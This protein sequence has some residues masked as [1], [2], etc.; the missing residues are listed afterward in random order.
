M[1]VPTGTQKETHRRSS[2][3]SSR[4]GSKRGSYLIR[5]CNK[6][7]TV[8]RGSSTTYPIVL[9]ILNCWRATEERAGL[10]RKRSKDRQQR[11]RRQW[12]RL[13][14]WWWRKGKIQTP[15]AIRRQWNSWSSKGDNKLAWSLILSWNKS[16][17]S[18]MTGLTRRSAESA[19]FSK[20]LVNHQP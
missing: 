13:S 15:K 7:E 9:I 20:A 11:W 6:R 1:L 3:W 10:D 5:S 14:Q 8:R 16:N 19:N 18:K 4:G 12:R 2:W 17:S